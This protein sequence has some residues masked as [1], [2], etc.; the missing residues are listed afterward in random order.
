MKVSGVF[1]G[2]GG[3]VGGDTRLLPVPETTAHSSHTSAVTGHHASGSQCSTSFI[4][5]IL[6]E[7]DSGNHKDGMEN[8]VLWK[9]EVEKKNKTSLIIQKFYLFMK[10]RLW[11]QVSGAI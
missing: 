6:A 9:L 11:E 5:A 4:W 1:E 8:V 10:Q 7:W 2:V 3:G